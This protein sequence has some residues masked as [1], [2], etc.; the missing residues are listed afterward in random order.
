MILGIRRAFVVVG[1]S[2]C[3]VAGLASIRVA[4]ALTEAAAPPSA[5]PVSLES[6]RGELTAEQTRGQALQ[7]QLDELMGVTTTLS[8]ALAGTRYQVA[9][10]GLTAAE[11]ATRLDAAQAK[12]AQLKGLLAQARARLAALNGSA[13]GS[14]GSGGSGGSG[15]AP[16][17]SGL[18]LVVSLGGGGVNVDWSSCST[19]GF[20]GYA[21]VRSTDHEVHWPPE[22]RDTEVARIT[23]PST[24]SWTDTG[25]PSGTMTYQVYC[26]ATRG[27]ETK[28]V[29]KT[30]ARSIAVP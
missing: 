15:G 5:P 24:T 11:L 8:D 27:G 3:L 26:L 19:D 22:D 18:T 14:R 9:A 1:V 29:A 21:V 23:S 7:A 6:L 17:P 4:A 13:A 16:P 28:S 12:L 10:E 30:P 25:A 20:S 2:A